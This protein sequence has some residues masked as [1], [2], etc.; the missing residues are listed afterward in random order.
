[1]RLDHGRIQFDGA[2][3]LGDSVGRMVPIYRCQPSQVVQ[4]GR[5]GIALQRRTKGCYG[6]VELLVAGVIAAEQNCILGCGMSLGLC[7]QGSGAGARG[8]GGCGKA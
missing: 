5:L 1:M 6:A 7:H 3:Q 2:L 4:L 8:V